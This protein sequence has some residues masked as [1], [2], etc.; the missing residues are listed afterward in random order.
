MDDSV[1]VGI[2]KVNMMAIP[3]EKIINDLFLAVK[4][5]EKIS[6]DP[7]QAK[8]SSCCEECNGVRYADE[9][10][11]KLKARKPVNDDYLPYEQARAERF[12]VARDGN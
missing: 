1:E 10:L 7:A 12:G 3:K 4:A 2:A 11:A 5:L 6:N 8:G 9:A